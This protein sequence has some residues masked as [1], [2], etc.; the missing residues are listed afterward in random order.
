MMHISKAKTGDLICSVVKYRL[1]RTVLPGL[2]I[3][4]NKEIDFR[5]EFY[6]L[7][8]LTQ[9]MTLVKVVV[10]SDEYLDNV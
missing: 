4:I 8:V 6:I 5:N 9:N 2:I 7:R 1:P 10:D 3:S